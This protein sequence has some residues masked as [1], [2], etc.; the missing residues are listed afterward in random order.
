VA[1]PLLLLDHLGL[2]PRIAPRLEAASSYLAL[3]RGRMVASGGPA[4][5]LARRI[6]RTV[7]LVH[8]S[9]GASGVAALRWRTAFNLNAKSPALAS[10]QPELCHDEIAGWGLGGDVTRQILT[11]VLLRHNDEDPRLVRRFAAVDELMTEVVADVLEVRSE[12]TDDLSRFL[13]LSMVGELVSLLRAG[14][15]GV[16]PGPVPALVGAPLGHPV[17]EQGAASLG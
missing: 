9:E 10:L 16:D 1:P 6:G 5:E 11:L 17:G 13:E 14:A 2:A 12:A 15:E 4:T 7:P 8:G 3:R